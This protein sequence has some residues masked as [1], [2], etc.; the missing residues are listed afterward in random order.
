ML[1]FQLGQ[2]S[3]DNLLNCHLRFTC[4]SEGGA[5]HYSRLG[6]SQVA[7]F[8]GRQVDGEATVIAEAFEAA[9]LLFLLN[10]LAV[11][12]DAQAGVAGCRCIRGCSRVAARFFWCRG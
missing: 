4:D 9:V 1:V 6:V 2:R 3:L 10:E 12:S 11:C 5:T 8:G 7:T